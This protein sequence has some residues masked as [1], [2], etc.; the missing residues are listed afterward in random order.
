[1]IAR[2]TF[3]A[4]GVAAAAVRTSRAQSADVDCVIVGAGAA[5][6]GAARELARAGLTFSIIEARDRLGG[7]VFTDRSL[8]EPFDAGALFIH[9]AERNP[10]RAIAAELGVATSEESSGGSFQL[11]RD[12]KPLEAR[13]MLL[14]R[15]AFG[16]FG[17]RRRVAEL[18][19]DDVS[20]A[21]LVAGDD[22]ALRAAAAGD[23][24]FSMGDDPEHVSVL[25]YEQLWSGD[26]LVLPGGYGSLVAQ[27]LSQFPVALST[28]ARAVRWDG[29]GVV[30]ETP[31]GALRARA[32]IVTVSAGVLQSGAIAFMP[33]LPQ[34][35]LA[36]LDGLHMGAL[37]K[38]ALTFDGHL[39]LG[40]ETS[41]FEVAGKAG[42]AFSVYAWPRGRDIVVATLAGSYAREVIA[43]GEAGAIDHA[44]G[45]IAGMIGED[46]RRR[47]RA[48][49]LAGW[50]A[51]PFALGSYSLAK[52]RRP[53]VREA[54]ARPVGERIWFAGEATAGGGAMTAGGATLA[55]E[56]AAKEAAATLRR[57]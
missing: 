55:G 11:Y 20:F 50:A 5:A 41:L 31:A 28:P 54:L 32:V 9:W 30:V 10:W 15:A 27:A 17:A 23:S 13:E 44:V 25:D 26:D 2:R 56:R 6:Y 35:T 7:R 36:A 29:P 53:G 8:G 52:P 22:E 43:L 47:F 19:R 24:L 18:N 48:G 46:A 14:R 38:I 1:M 51:D 57:G 33:G 40:D 45:R 12:G 42:G 3:L 39:G 21:D 34:A 16:G 4:G 37:T 49:R